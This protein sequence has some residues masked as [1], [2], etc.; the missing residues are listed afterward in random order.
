VVAIGRVPRGGVA[1]GGTVEHDEPRA[2]AGAHGCAAGQGDALL[3]NQQKVGALVT[4]Y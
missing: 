1:G 3:G 2:A 4:Q